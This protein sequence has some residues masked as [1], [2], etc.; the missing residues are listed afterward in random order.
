MYV[1][2]TNGRVIYIH[3]YIYIYVYVLVDAIES[4]QNKSADTMKT[5]SDTIHAPIC[6]C[7][8]AYIAIESRRND[9]NPV[10][11]RFECT[12]QFSLKYT[13]ER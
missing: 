9:G 1:C 5:C 7:I 3:T 4:K 8:V 2:V 13:R 6:A 11:Q 12:I 10:G